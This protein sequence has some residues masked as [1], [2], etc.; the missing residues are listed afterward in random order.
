MTVLLTGAA[1]TIG[2]AL[3]VRLPA[4]GWT[5]RGFDRV[6]VD[7]GVVGAHP[8]APAHQ[9]R[10]CDGAGLGGLALAYNGLPPTISTSAG[11]G[12][13]KIVSTG[14]Y[15]GVLSLDVINYTQKLDM[16][17]LG[18]GKMFLGA[19]LT[20]NISQTIYFNQALVPGAP[21]TVNTAPVFNAS[22]LTTPVYRLGGGG[23]QGQFNIGAAAFE[24]A[25]PR[26]AHRLRTLLVWVRRIHGLV[27]P[28]LVELCRRSPCGWSRPSSISP[29]TS[30]E[31]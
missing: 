4:Y 19:S 24:N 20:G 29:K 8:V 12:G 17:T 7:G 14:D 10:G 25:S 13:V 16:S 28:S 30:Q 23:N 6:P 18:G 3:P 2:S 9:A 27:A 22:T 31:F 15:D 1:G 11:A 26:N 21:D 5:V